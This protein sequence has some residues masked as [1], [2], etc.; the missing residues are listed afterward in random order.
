LIAVEVSEAGVRFIHFFDALQTAQAI[1][2]GLIAVL[3]M[4]RLLSRRK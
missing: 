1:A 2:G 4:R 3:I